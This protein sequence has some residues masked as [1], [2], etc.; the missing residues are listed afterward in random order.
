MVPPP[1]FPWC[2]RLS[3]NPHAWKHPNTHVQL[4]IERDELTRDVSASSPTPVVLTLPLS[5]MELPSR[6]QLTPGKQVSSLS[7][8]TLCACSYGPTSHRPSGGGVRQT[9]PG[10]AHPGPQAGCPQDTLQGPEEGQTPRLGVPQERSRHPE[11]LPRVDVSALRSGKTA[12]WAHGAWEFI[13]CIPFREAVQVGKGHRPRPRLWSDDVPGSPLSRHQHPAALRGHGLHL[14]H[15]PPQVHGRGVLLLQGG[16]L[17]QEVVGKRAQDAA[18]Q[19]Q[20]LHPAEA[21][22]V[23]H[24]DA[25]HA[26]HAQ[27]DGRRADGHAGPGPVTQHLRTE[28]ASGRERVGER[29]GCERDMVMGCLPHAP[30]PGDDPTTQVG[31]LDQKSNPHPSVSRRSDHGPRQ[32]QWLFYMRRL[33][34]RR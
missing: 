16:P 3:V 23:D 12:S 19:R 34:Y 9:V 4:L 18:R 30:R 5:P 32:D 29:H 14:S 6:N 24:G 13:K 17:H 28:G 31:A 7:P 20:V 25:L 15:D 33:R 1:S 2:V 8:G 26:Q 27:E 21:L 10:Q 11:R 22:H